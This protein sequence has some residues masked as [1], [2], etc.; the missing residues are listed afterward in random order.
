MLQDCFRMQRGTTLITY[1]I[2][3][4][5]DPVVII[6]IG[7]GNIPLNIP[8]SKVKVTNCSEIVNKNKQILKYCSKKF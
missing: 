5:T 2:A 6:D 3:R 7:V 4:G 1:E 8:L